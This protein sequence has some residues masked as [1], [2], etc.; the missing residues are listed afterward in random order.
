[1]RLNGNTHV[2][3]SQLQTSGLGIG[4][5]S[6]RIAN[7]TELCAHH[8]G[9][10]GTLHLI[11]NHFLCKWLQHS[12]Y[13]FGHQSRN[14]R[15]RADPAEFCFLDLFCNYPTTI[16][17]NE[18]II[19]P[20]QVDCLWSEWLPWA[21]CVGSMVGCSAGRQTRARFISRLPNFGGKLCL[22]SHTDTQWCNVDCPCIKGAIQGGGV[23]GGAMLGILEQ[24]AGT[25]CM[26]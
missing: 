20:I 1:M 14:T 21:P 3:N 5:V 24:I 10:L 11:W 9:S 13:N 7:Q 16:S 19:F 6:F 25:N 22:G 26:D 8:E 12:R 17:L 18:D 23:V 2:W 15:A 4:S